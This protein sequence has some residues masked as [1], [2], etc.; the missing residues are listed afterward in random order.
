MIEVAVKNN[1]EG[2]PAIS[3]LIPVYNSERTLKK[4]LDS[5]IAQ[6][7]IKYEVIIV[8]DGSQDLSMDVIND[9]LSLD[10]FTCIKHKN[11]RGLV[12][13]RISA[14]KE[15]IGEFIVFLDSDDELISP[16]S[17]SSIYSFTQSNNADIFHFYSEIYDSL[18]NSKTNYNWSRIYNGEISANSALEKMIIDR[19]IDGQVWGKLYRADIMKKSVIGILLPDG[20]SKSEDLYFNS[21]FL[22]N[23][24]SY[25]GIKYKFYRYKFG[26]GMT[27][28]NREILSLHDWRNKISGFVILKHLSDYFFSLGKINLS[29]VIEDSWFKLELENAMQHLHWVDNKIL[30][31]ALDDLYL[32]ASR[33]PEFLYKSLSNEFGK[34]K[35]DKNFVAPNQSNFLKF[36][37][38]LVRYGFFYTFRRS[39]KYIFFRI[40]LKLKY[41]FL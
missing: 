9:Y 25:F 31:S 21:I 26:F 8:D 23:A 16:T 2:E 37:I 33:K 7:N 20:L 5:V 41:F 36:K 22:S 39:S 15:S 30:E 12:Q 3:V 34:L 38:F 28:T 35:R 1:P 24:K 32:N 4:C 18:S 13:A 6:K 14:I 17:L 10:N 27:A 40:Y 29:C 11:N 19:S